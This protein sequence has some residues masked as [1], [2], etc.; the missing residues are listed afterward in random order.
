MTKTSDN[1][2]RIDSNSPAIPDDTAI[3]T[4]TEYSCLKKQVEGHK[5]QLKS[6]KD[7][8]NWTFG[9][10]V[11]VL[12]VCVIA[13]VGFLLDAWTMHRYS[14]DQFRKELIKTRETVESSN[15]QKSDLL[16]RQNEAKFLIKSEKSTKKVNSQT[17]NLIFQKILKLEKEMKSFKQKAAIPNIDKK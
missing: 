3:I 10:I 17:Q 16:N 15:S 9:F 4:N 1:I 2:I 14:Y 11:A 12:A 13:T 6:H 8:L 5:G 7:L